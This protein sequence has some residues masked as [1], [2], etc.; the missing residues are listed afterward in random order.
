MPELDV[1]GGPKSGSAG[2][3]GAGKG[4]SDQVKDQA[5]DQA[6]GRCVFCGEG[7]TVERGRLQGQTDHSIPKSLDGNDTLENAQ[8]ACAGCNNAKGTQTTEEF[9]GQ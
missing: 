5:R 4:F 7:T 6:G 1:P 8:H 2:G 3:P 9:L